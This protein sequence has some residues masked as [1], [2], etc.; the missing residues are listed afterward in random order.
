[1]TFLLLLF[2]FIFASSSTSHTCIFRRVYVLTANQWALN[3]ILTHTCRV[4]SCVSFFSV[5]SFYFLAVPHIVFFCCLVPSS[6]CMPFALAYLSYRITSANSVSKTF[7]SLKNRLRTHT[8]RHTSNSAVLWDV[9]KRHNVKCRMLNL[10]RALCLTNKQQNFVVEPFIIFR[11]VFT[12]V[13]C[14]PLL[15]VCRRFSSTKRLY[16]FFFIFIIIIICLC[17]VLFQ[18]QFTFFF[19]ST[20]KTRNFCCFS[21]SKKK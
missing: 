10:M 11:I 18:F 2:I 1:M 19:S 15:I 8:H 9:C 3:T 6:F 7:I 13:C 21:Q 4:D 14:E 20:K 17:S 12:V 5:V 16:I